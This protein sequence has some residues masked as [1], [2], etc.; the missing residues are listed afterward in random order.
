MQG[1]PKDFISVA[2]WSAAALWELNTRALELK[3][4]HAAGERPALQLASTQTDPEGWT[5][6]SESGSLQRLEDE[7]QTLQARWTGIEE[8]LRQRDTEVSRLEQEMHARATA[9][10]ALP[11][12]HPAPSFSDPEQIRAPKTELRLITSISPW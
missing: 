1:D 7:F 12:S 11:S 2:D 9:I 10:E 3:A 6:I 5:L 4:Q 8:E